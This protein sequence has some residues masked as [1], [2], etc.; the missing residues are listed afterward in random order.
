M[1]EIPYGPYR[2]DAYQ[3]KPWHLKPFME[4]NRVTYPYDHES[5]VLYTGVNK[6]I[7]F[8]E[9]SDKRPESS[10]NPKSVLNQGELR[11]GNFMASEGGQ[12]IHAEGIFFGFLGVAHAYS[13]KHTKESGIGGAVLEIQVPVESLTTITPRNPKGLNSRKELDDEMGSPEEF[14]KR[15]QYYE[16]AESIHWV[17]TDSIPLE[18]VTGVWDVENSRKPKFYGLKE[19]LKTLK[20]QYPEHVPGDS[21]HGELNKK[22]ERQKILNEL[23]EYKQI[24]SYLKEMDLNYRYLMEELERIEKGR[25]PRED[26][27]SLI[28]QYNQERRELG[29]ALSAD[30][31]IEE[32]EI[33]SVKKSAIENKPNEIYNRIKKAK[34]AA[35]EAIADEQDHIQRNDW[36]VEAMKKEKIFET[37]LEERIAEMIHQ[38]PLISS[39]K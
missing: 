8:R 16:N 17:Y 30:F 23:E 24:L 38:I 37:R 13:V 6:H 27:N 36:N 18:N 28:R 14:R 33:N 21:R 5:V 19:F 2:K 1:T 20:S 35:K 22:K 32:D 39:D 11:A 9:E 7:F 3:G 34:A 15:C 12:G 31:G 29:E 10:R 26:I 25:E 4:G